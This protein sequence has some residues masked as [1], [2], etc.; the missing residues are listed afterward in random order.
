MASTGEAAAAEPAGAA[1]ARRVTDAQLLDEAAQL[2]AR[3]W[4]QGALAE[5]DR[6]RVV[7]PWSEAASRWSPLG[8]LLSAWYASGAG[9]DVLARAYTA[10][11]FATGGRLEEWNATPWRTMRHVLSA[12]ARARET[13]ELNT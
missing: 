10:I 13:A 6:G 3:G 1:L 7:E 5:D 9:P 11:A 4:C 8:A 12:F 2:V